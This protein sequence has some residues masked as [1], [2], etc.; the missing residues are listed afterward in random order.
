[1]RTVILYQNTDLSSPVSGDN[2]RI[3][4]FLFVFPDIFYFLQTAD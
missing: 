4:I 3:V 1:M 2:K